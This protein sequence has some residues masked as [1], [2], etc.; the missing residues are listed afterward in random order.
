MGEGESPQSLITFHTSSQLPFVVLCFSEIHSL[1]AL[2]CPLR[3]PLTLTHMQFVGWTQGV[4][5]HDAS[6]PWCGRITWELPRRCQP[7]FG[8]WVIMQSLGSWSGEAEREAGRR[9][10]AH[11]PFT[12]ASGSVSERQPTRGFFSPGFPFHAL[13]ALTPLLGPSRRILLLGQ[14]E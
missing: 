3:R 13:S 10:C 11:L 5:S 8:S 1:D 7:S 2:F 4:Q 9:V 12:A 14:T 6:C